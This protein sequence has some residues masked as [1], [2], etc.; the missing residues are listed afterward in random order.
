MVGKDPSLAATP[1]TITRQ[2]EFGPVCTEIKIFPIYIQ[3]FIYRWTILLEYDL[4]ALI[5]FSLQFQHLSL[6]SN[7]WL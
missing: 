7:K 1:P 4:C 5:F 2:V 6:V 3:L